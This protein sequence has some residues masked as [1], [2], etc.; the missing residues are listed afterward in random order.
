M[1]VFQSGCHS[2]WSWIC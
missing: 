2:S 1:I